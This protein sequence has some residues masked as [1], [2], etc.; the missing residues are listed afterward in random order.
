MKDNEAVYTWHEI[1]S[2]SSSAESDSV[3]E[4]IEDNHL[5]TVCH[6]DFDTVT[7]LSIT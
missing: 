1:H 7:Q 6:I 5:D 4:V 3:A 2:F